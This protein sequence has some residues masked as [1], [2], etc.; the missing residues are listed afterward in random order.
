MRF[1]KPKF[2]DLKKPNL[3]SYI[4]MPFTI[5]VKINNILL[6]LK[7][8]KKNSKIKSI[9]IGNIYL[10]G[11]G[12]TPA[13]IRL[14]NICKNIYSN[15][16][17]GKKYYSSQIDEQILLK[18]KTNLICERDRT[19]IIKKAI[20]QN[21]RLIIFD[22][23]L[24]DKKINY[25]LQ[26]V[27]FDKKDWIGNGCILPS[28]PLRE[29]LD[30]LKK[31]DIVFLKSNNYDP[32]MNQIINSIKNQNSE[33]KIFQTYYK[34][35]NLNKF[36]IEDKFIIFS[37]IGNPR[38]FREILTANK[39][40]IIEEIVFPDHNSYK[41]RDIEKIKEDAKSLNAKIIT[42]EKDY[43]K[44]SEKNRAG[45]DFLEID[46]IIEDEEKLINFIKSKID[47]KH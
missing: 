45:I 37:G 24:Q 10:G 35:I 21:N 17:T 41:D 5:P 6:N 32:S 23:G 46:L 25:D 42:T 20:N 16:C 28:G 31:Y 2:W 38:S 18:N 34:P 30:S 36:N 29:K 15:V 19:K 26:I 22:D 11:T 12:K 44:L 40:N 7:S 43:V 13:T 9:C 27:C 33:I 39:M 4:L 8:S 14:F 1:K 3:L 47:E